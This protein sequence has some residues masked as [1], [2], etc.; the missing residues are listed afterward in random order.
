MNIVSKRN[1]YGLHTKVIFRLGIF[2]LLFWI[3]IT[4]LIYT[5]ERREVLINARNNCKIV[6]SQVDAAQMYVREELRPIMY[7]LLPE[8]EF[9]PEAMSTT[10][11]SR[12]IVERFMEQFP[13]YYFKFAT[14]NPRNPVNIANNAE[15]QVIGRFQVNPELVE[16]CGIVVWEDEQYLSIATPITFNDSCLKCHGDPLDAPASL[17]ERYGD[18]AGFG[19]STN[20]IAIKAVGV[21]ISAAMLLAR[22]NTFILGGFAGAFLLCLFFLTSFQIRRLVINPVGKLR[23]G[24]ESL[25]RGDLDYRIEIHSQ[26]E[27]EDLANS[28][29]FMADKL[30]D[31]YEDLERKIAERTDDLETIIESSPTGLVVVDIETRKVIKINSRALNMIGCE[32]D[33]V[34]AAPCADHFCDRC[35]GICPVLDSGESV[36]GVERTLTN[37]DGT[38]I[39]ILKSVVR[40]TIDDRPCLLETFADITEIKELNKTLQTATENLAERG[41]QL[42]IRNRMSNIFLTT[43]EED[44]YNEVLKVVQDELKSPLGLFGYLNE[45]GALV[46]PSLTK[47][48]WDQCQ[49]TDRSPVFPPE[50]WEGIWG[51]SLV[52]GNTVCKDPGLNVPEGH[53][54]LNRALCT[55]VV[56]HGTVVG[57]LLVG[58]KETDYTEYDIE[59]IETIA[60]HIAP[61]LHSKLA[62]ERADHERRLAEIKVQESEEKYRLLV[63]HQNDMVIKLDLENRFT[64]VSPTFQ[65]FIGKTEEEL[66]GQEFHPFIFEEDIDITLK[67]IVTSLNSQPHTGYVEHRAYSKN[68]LRWIAWVGNGVLDEKGNPVEIVAVGRDITD[69]KLAEEELR[70]F[71]TISDRSSYGAAILD[72][73]GTLLYV[74][75]TFAQMNG[76]GIDDLVGTS[77]EK[78]YSKDQYKKVVFLN[79]K[80][81]QE[82]VY[83]AEKIWNVRSDGSTFPTLVNATLLIDENGRPLYISMTAVDISDLVGAQDRLEAVVQ[84][85]AS[86]NDQLEMAITRANQLAEESAAN[87]LAK[88]EFLANM[89]HE[90]RTPLNAVIGM[91]ELILG[92]KLSVQQQEYLSISKSSADTLLTLINDIL[93]LSK[94]EAGKLSL[95]NTEFDLVQVVSE[96]TMSFAHKAQQAEL[97]LNSRIAPDVPT[98]LY[99]DPTRLRQILFNLIGNAVKFT[100]TGGV[101]LEASL[102]ELE[103]NYAVIEFNITDTGIGIPPD[104]VDRIFD[105]FVQADGSTTRRYGGTGLG[106]AISKRIVEAMDGAISVQSKLYSGSTF[107]FTVKFGVPSGTGAASHEEFEIP[108]GLNFLYIGD[109]SHDLETIQDSCEKV[110][111]HLTLVSHDRI[112]PISIQER[113]KHHVNFNLFIL[114]LTTDGFDGREILKSLGTDENYRLTPI[115][116][117]VSADLGLSPDD[118]KELG[119]DTWLYKPISSLGLN[120]ILTDILEHPGKVNPIHA[121]RHDPLDHSDPSLKVLVAEDNPVNQKVAVAMLQRLGHSY[122]LVADG[123]GALRALENEDFDLILMD[124]QMP[125]LDGIEAAKAIRLNPRYNNLP[126]VALTAYAME[127]DRSRIMETGMDD[128]LPKPVKLASLQNIIE[129]WRDGRIIDLAGEEF[130]EMSPDDEI[131]AILNV[132][133]ALEQIGGDRDLL[134][135]VYEIYLADVPR[136][137]DELREAIDAG[138]LETAMRAAHSLKGASA[139]IAAETVRAISQEIEQFSSD[140]DLDKAASMVPALETAMD[141]LKIELE[142]I[143]TV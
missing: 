52:T 40:V 119:C 98:D 15:V 34:I 49:V 39:P 36:Q 83:S 104:K 97:S 27:I 35:D 73:D 87:A 55:A 64:F 72:L 12:S 100:E 131:T 89:S 61:I 102:K 106:L 105:D 121:D 66:L 24:V 124:V 136:K 31:S 26:D 28:F 16:W 48:I 120:V 50:K 68:G 128:Y 8:D 1:L 19:R 54:K 78:L 134:K 122:T 112:D 110:G 25:G 67:E 92:T 5:M 41:K 10:F 79:E 141:R 38:E 127:G 46:L 33:E 125:R 75:E 91:T 109:P 23:N 132:E 13:E 133:L 135:E 17:V 57:L 94:I 86:A 43:P 76:C 103:N 2:F 44:L 22:N 62:R 117:I 20:D 116:A 90:I 11:M 42:S 96:I 126:I 84:Q 114:D 6:I 51:Q 140:G 29:N 21:P 123:F 4:C 58:D 113:L 63:E 130:E 47:E 71:K 88:S 139:S 53:I 108:A 14:T 81:M 59:V 118:L 107:T 56:H 101:T 93:D 60:G 85:L 74:N 70:K 82:G 77:A 143:I 18:V 115:V 9:V 95:E 37:A 69:Q 32:R 129:K 3:L 99:G 111:A 45:N 80:L 142:K 30:K 65:E 138:D 137:F 7:D